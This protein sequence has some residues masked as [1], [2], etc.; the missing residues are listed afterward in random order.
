[1]LIDFPAIARI[2][3]I[4]VTTITFAI[5]LLSYSRFRNRK[6]ALLTVGFG[7]F[8]VHGMISI[9]EL[10]NQ[11]YNILFT[12]NLHLVIDAI[13][14]LFLLVGTLTELKKNV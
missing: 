3:F 8:F 1:M 9:P 12:E 11:T 14:V 4:T 5:A 2:M 7:L 10:F 13:A 6:T